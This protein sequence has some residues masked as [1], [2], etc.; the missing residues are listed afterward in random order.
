MRHVVFKSISAALY[1]AAFFGAMVFGQPKQNFKI[2]SITV[3]P[4]LPVLGPDHATV[5]NSYGGLT[6]ASDE[7]STILPP[8]MFPGQT[9]YFVLI[10]SRT[11]L[12]PVESGLVFLRSTELPDKNGQW[13]LDFAQPYGQFAPAAPAGGQNGSVFATAM[14]HNLCPTTAPDPT[15]DLNYAAPGTVIVDPTNP[16]IWGSENLLMVYEGT[17]RCIGISTANNGNNNFYSTIGIATS[18]DFGLSWPV[19]RANYAELPLINQTEGPDAP[20]GAWGDN[21]CTGAYCA[22]AHGF[23]FPPQYGRYAVSGPVVTVQEAMNQLSNGL[24]SNVGDSEPAAF[25]DDL[26]GLPVDAYV[27]HTYLPGQFAADSTLYPGVQS[28]LSV[29]QIELNG[30]TARL[31]AKKWY[32]GSFSALGLGEDG[33]GQ[34][35][36]IFTNVAATLDQYHHCLAPSQARSSGSISYIDAVH[37]YI[38]F[39]VCLSPTEPAHETEYQINN[40]G[41]GAWFYSKL[42]A[43]QYDLSRQDQWSAPNEVTNSWSTF[44]QNGGCEKDFNGWYPTLMS[45]NASPG[46]LRTLGYVFYMNGCTDLG[47]TGGRRYST[48]AFSI[49][50]Q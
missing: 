13:S 10:A 39:F 49:Q 36:P 2:A 47:T 43:D 23:Q 9:D 11:Q 44:A 24:A 50:L 17:N 30:G 14:A 19:Y 32:N 8:G 28:D 12:A 20:V 48:R 41:G 21:V 7:H 27:V 46:H 16:G 35:S 26:H 15:F 38:L 29:L 37:Q 22:S 6:T 1:C 4:G 42:D 33:G 18:S 31:K 5:L 45:L 25:V 34:E 3:Q 40:P